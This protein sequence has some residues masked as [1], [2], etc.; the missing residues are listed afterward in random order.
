MADDAADNVFQKAALKSFMNLA[1]ILATVVTFIVYAYTDHELEPATIF[2]ALQIFGVI[3]EPITDLSFSL[4]ELLNT[5]IASRR[6]RD[7]MVGEELQQIIQRPHQ[8]QYALH[9]HGN[10]IYDTQAGP[11]LVA[12]TGPGGRVSKDRPQCTR[13]K[14]SQASEEAQQL[15][16]PGQPF[17]F[18][19]EHLKIKRGDLVC[20][21]GKIASGKTTLMHAILGELRMLNGHIIHCG[22]LS[23]VSQRPWIQSGSIRAQV[24]FGS[25]AKADRLQTAI[26]SCAL[27]VDLTELVDGL[28]TEIG[29]KRL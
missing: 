11:E 27:D 29:G 10:F 19:V 28:D 22:K 5:I 6:V 3:A 24:L 25:S 14:P 21:V 13:D 26:N 7:I 12:Q 16:L 18:H 9:I 2:A 15:Q 4:I 20:I 1:P 23:Y 17:G 8:S